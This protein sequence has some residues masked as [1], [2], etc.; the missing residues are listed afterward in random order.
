MRFPDSTEIRHLDHAPPPGTR[1]RSASGHEWLVAEVLQ[2]GR[3]TYTVFCVGRREYLEDFGTG[4]VRARLVAGD[5]AEDID[6]VADELLQRV[7]RSIR[8]RR[9]RRAET[10][11]VASYTADGRPFELVIRAK[12]LAPAKSEALEHANH[13]NMTLKDVRPGPEW[14]N[15]RSGRARRGRRWRWVARRRQ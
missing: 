3:D 11:F 8:D 12:S 1:L 13:W 10:A 5:L 7:R 14:L 2:S 4:S 9:W 6:D 15:T